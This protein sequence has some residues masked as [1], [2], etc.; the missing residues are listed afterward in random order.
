MNKELFKAL[1]TIRETH[2]RIELASKV[3]ETSRNKDHSACLVLESLQHS[4]RLLREGY[5]QVKQVY[6]SDKSEELRESHKEWPI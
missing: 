5:E 1:L 4:K 6:L 2:S 3:L